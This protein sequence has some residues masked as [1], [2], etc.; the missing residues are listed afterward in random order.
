VDA[1]FKTFFNSVVL[2]WTTITEYQRLESFTNKHLFL[3]VLEAEESNR[4]QRAATVCSKNILSI[5]L[6][7]KP[8]IVH[9]V[10]TWGKGERGKRERK[11]KRER[12]RRSSRRRVRDRR[13]GKEKGGKGEG[14]R[15]EEKRG[16]EESRRGNW[17]GGEGKGEG[18]YLFLK[19]HL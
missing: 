10:L 15:K 5:L 7:H 18:S 11:R 6:V 4:K 17:R 2:V 8:S 19:G 13:K 9:C 14:K 12:R 1:I 16:G 3:I